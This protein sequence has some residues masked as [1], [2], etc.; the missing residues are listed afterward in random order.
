MSSLEEIE[1]FLQKERESNLSNCSWAKLNK[2]LKMKKID[3]YIET[4]KTENKLNA[5]ESQKLQVFLKECVN[6]GRIQKV[7]D[8]SYDKNTGKIKK[9]NGLGHNDKGNYTLKNTETT[10]KNSTLKHMGKRPKQNGGCSSSSSHK[11]QD[12]VADSSDEDDDDG[13]N[14]GNNDNNDNK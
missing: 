3:E 1:S 5:E 12:N 11:K 14:D 10:K 7:K 8:I 2:S 13:D 6:K 9:I 4:Y